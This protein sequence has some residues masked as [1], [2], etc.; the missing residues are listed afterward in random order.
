MPSSELRQCTLLL[1]QAFEKNSTEKSFGY[2]Q[3][4][5]LAN[6]NIFTN[7]SE[8]G[9]GIA[10]GRHYSTIISYWSSCHIF[11]RLSSLGHTPFYTDAAFP[12]CGCAG[13]A[14]SGAWA[15]FDEFNRINIEVNSHLGLSKDLSGGSCL[16]IILPKAIHLPADHSKLF[17]RLSPRFL[18]QCRWIIQG[19]G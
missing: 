5:P 2:G 18:N 12:C 16:S 1:Q 13:L 8:Y 6:I 3:G 9:E 4:I 17:P 11:A 15:C 14:S 7:V 19:S 10:A